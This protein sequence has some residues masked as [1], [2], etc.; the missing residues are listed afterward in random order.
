MS[1]VFSTTAMSLDGSTT[2]RQ[3]DARSAAGVLLGQ[4]RLHL[5]YEG[6]PA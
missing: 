6:L 3:D 4:G 1:R 5:R 2:G